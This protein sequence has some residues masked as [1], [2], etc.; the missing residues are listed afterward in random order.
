MPGLNRG[1]N[2]LKWKHRQELGYF[3]T[4][5][6]KSDLKGTLLTTFR[7]RLQTPWVQSKERGFT[8]MRLDNY[9]VINS[10]NCYLKELSYRYR[11]GKGK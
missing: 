3:L 9:F 4:V 5:S 8:R 7:D 6:L 1:K 2:P 10:F 11:Q